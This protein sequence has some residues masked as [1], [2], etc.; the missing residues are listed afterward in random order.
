MAYT[1]TCLG[2][3]VVQEGLYNF[4]GGNH[5][6]LFS[7]EHFEAC[8][9]FVLGGNAAIPAVVSNFDVFVARRC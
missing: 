6:T 7:F 1:F 8:A 4:D 3:F 9:C 5:F 2:R